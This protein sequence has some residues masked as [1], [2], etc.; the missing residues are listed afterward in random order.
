MANTTPLAAGSAQPAADTSNTDGWNRYNGTVLTICILG[1][2]FDVYEQTILQLVTPLLIKE[3]QITPA[4]IGNVTTIARWIGLIGTFVF[5]V[6]ADLYG[7]KPVLIASI[8]GYSIF[9]GLTGFAYDWMSLL[10]FTALTRIALSGENPVG[11]LMVSE[12]APTKWRATALG[13]LVGGY[14]I[15]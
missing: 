2:A 9:S 15:G 5:P 10:F 8:L 6:L 4:T 12:T 3:W 11:M 7:R 1:W 14:P 13:G